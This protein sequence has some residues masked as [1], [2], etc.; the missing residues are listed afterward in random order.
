VHVRDTDIIY[1]LEGAATVVTGGDVVETSTVAPDEI[2]GAAIR[3]GQAQRLERGDVFIV[4]RGVPHWFKDVQ[5]PFLYYVVKATAQPE[6]T[7]P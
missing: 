1:V 2:R 4:P 7:L 3:G 5:G 6:G